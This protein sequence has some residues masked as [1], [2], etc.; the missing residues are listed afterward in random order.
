M[1]FS[2]RFQGTMGGVT[3]MIF[4]RNVFMRSSDIAA[5][6]LI[7]PHPNADMRDRPLTYYLPHEL[8][9]VLESRAFGRG[10]QFRY[11]QWLLEGYADYIGKGGQ[12][13]YAENLRLLKAGAPQ[14]DFARS[15]LYRRFHLE[16]AYYLD[17]RRWTVRQLFAARPTAAQALAAV[18]AEP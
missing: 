13:D 2:E 9:H 18:K 5:N 3:D 17:H 12:F 6:R 8:T 10:P 15:G 14:L 11:P 4:A 16:V 1:L 7:P